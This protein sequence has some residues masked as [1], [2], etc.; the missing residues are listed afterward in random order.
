LSTG[1]SLA[2]DAAHVSDHH[3]AGAVEHGPVVAV[4]DLDAQAFGRD[5]DQQLGPELPQHRAGLDHVVQPLLERFQ[6]LA[7]VRVVAALGL[8]V[9]GF[10][11]HVHPV[12]AAAGNHVGGHAAFFAAV[13]GHL[14]RHLELVGDA[15]ELLGRGDAQD[16]HHQEKSEHGRHEVGKRDLPGAAVVGGGL[17]GTLDDDDFAGGFAHG[18]SVACVAG[19]VSAP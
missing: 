12:H 3:R 4:D 15:L 2:Q 11:V 18:S 1:A 14:Q 8:G 10:P 19:R 7:V 5:V 16:P 9:P 13:E 17:H 6:P